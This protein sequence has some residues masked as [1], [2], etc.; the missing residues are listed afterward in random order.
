MVESFEEA[1]KKNFKANE[2]KYDFVNL[3]N[4]FFNMNNLRGLW[5]GYRNS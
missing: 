5:M 2:Q 4:V 3:K 1:K